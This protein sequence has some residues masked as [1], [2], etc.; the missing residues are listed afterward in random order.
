M[1]LQYLK[2]VFTFF[3]A[4]AVA[5]TKAASHDVEWVY[6]MTENELCVAP[7]DALIQIAIVCIKNKYI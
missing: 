3:V 5:L 7:G 6:G 2:I 1:I 4:C